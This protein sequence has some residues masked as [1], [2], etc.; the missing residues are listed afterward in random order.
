[1]A[2][3]QV[4]IVKGSEFQG[5]FE[6]FSN[7]YYFGDGSLGGTSPEQA[8]TVINACLG[9]ERPIF[10][11]NVRFLRGYAR[12]LGLLHNPVEGPALADVEFPVNTMGN[13]GSPSP[14]MY[15][16][17]AVMVRWLLGG[18]R[19]LRSMLHTM[20]P[21]GLDET[22]RTSA[23][24]QADGPLALYAQNMLEGSFGGYQRISPSGERPSVVVLP[25]YLEHRQF[26]EGRKRQGVFG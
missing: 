26:H 7:V 10:A 15:A 18:K 5:R 24:P 3:I 9:M 23:T 22:G 1:M 25:R 13:F 20:T 19:F 12:E 16:E 11:M 6:E 14:T 8:E 4:T 17:C 2:G 21:H